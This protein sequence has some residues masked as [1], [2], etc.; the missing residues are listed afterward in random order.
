MGNMLISNIGQ[1]NNYHQMLKIISHFMQHL[2]LIT[3]REMQLRNE[4]SEAA[5]RGAESMQTT[6][7]GMYKNLTTPEMITLSI[8]F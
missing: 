6:F 3:H 7:D 8:D 1:D 5:N 4:L 2:G